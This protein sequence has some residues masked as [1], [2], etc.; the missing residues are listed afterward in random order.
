MARRARAIPSTRVLQLEACVNR[1]IQ[2]RFGQTM[3]VIGERFE[4]EFIADVSRQE[5]Y[6]RHDFILAQSRTILVLDM[7]RSARSREI[8][9]RV[10]GSR[11]EAGACHFLVQALDRNP[12]VGLYVDA[13]WRWGPCK[14]AHRLC[15]RLQ[16]E[17]LGPQGKT[18]CHG[19]CNEKPGPLGNAQARRKISSSFPATSYLS[20]PSRKTKP[21][22]A[23]FMLFAVAVCAPRSK[24]AL[25]EAS[26]RN[27]RRATR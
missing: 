8:P 27:S 2:A 4:I 10:L 15:E 25:S 26:R 24:N 14:A 12:V 3:V 7:T 6:F 1:H 11:D 13:Q 5:G 9:D 23:V 22:V 17:R 18:A 20:G 19:P 21:S 16:R